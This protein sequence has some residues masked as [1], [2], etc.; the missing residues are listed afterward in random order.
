M[1]EVSGVSQGMP[2]AE[3]VRPVVCSGRHTCDA[4]R[5]SEEVVAAVATDPA[6]L[7]TLETQAVVIRPALP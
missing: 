7:A 5:P 2:L 3:A 4:H 6:S 1:G